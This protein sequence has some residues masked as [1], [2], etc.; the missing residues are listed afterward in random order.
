MIPCD[1]ALPK[2]DL[3]GFDWVMISFVDAHG[4]GIRCLP[5]I[6]EIDRF[7]RWSTNTEDIITD[8]FINNDCVV[9]H[10]RIIPRNIKVE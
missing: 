7:G 8:D 10:W 4:K 6:A 2:K 5:Q 9:T 3:K 1:K